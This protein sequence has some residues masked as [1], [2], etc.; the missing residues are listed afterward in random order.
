[1]ITAWGPLRDDI[2]AFIAALDDA[3]RDVVY[4]TTKGIEQRDVLWHLMLHVVNHGTEH[5]SQVTLCLV[6]HDIDMGNLALIHHLRTVR[7]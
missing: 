4:H 3:G 1:M 5:R 6:L 7:A 2:R